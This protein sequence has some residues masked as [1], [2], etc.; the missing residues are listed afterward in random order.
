MANTLGGIALARGRLARGQTDLA[1]G[2]REAGDRIHHEAA[3]AAA[4]AEPL[5]D[6]RG[7]ERRLEAHQAGRD[8][9]SRTTTTERA[10]PR[11]QRL[12]DELG[13]LATTLAHEADHVDVGLGLA[14]DLAEQR[15]LAHA[16]AGEQARR[17]APRPR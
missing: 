7:H 11:P 15:R 4:V 14:R 12:L 5:G 6:R 3:R 13:H 2:A 1:L 10:R 17:A 16:R 8:R 9:W